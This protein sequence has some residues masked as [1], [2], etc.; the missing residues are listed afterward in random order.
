MKSYSRRDFTR[1]AG[2]AALFSP[3]LSLLEAGPARA[4]AGKAKYLYIFFT[5]GTDNAAWSPRGSSASSITFSKMTEPLS[6]IKD[7]LILI[8]KLSSNG[9]AGSHGAP[10]GL[11]GHNY[12]G[13]NMISL[14]QF[15]GDQLKAN[16]I[17][18]Q[19][20][21]LIMGGVP[22]EQLCTFYR[23]SRPLAPLATPSSAY[24]AIFGGALPP[25]T[26]PTGNNP[27]PSVEDRFGSPTL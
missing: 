24:Q 8:E 1:H 27:A 17:R 5:N 18:T 16:G 10:G 12:G 2:L 6:A 19:I 20:P 22:S 15:V 26:E 23:D 4:A 14:E 21:S 25:P 9:T 7:N 11:T 3:F 13:A